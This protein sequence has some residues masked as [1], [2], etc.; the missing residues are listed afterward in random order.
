MGGDATRQARFVLALMLLAAVVRLVHLGLPPLW[1]DEAFSLWMARHSVS[2]I[3][4]WTARLDA[5]PP[6]Y[7]VL[8]H[9]W[10][11]LGDRVGTLRA[12]SAMAELL[13]IP[14]A[15]L[16]G[17]AI[18]GASLGL[19]TA[20]LLALSPFNVWYGQEARM[21]PL[22]MLAA[23][24]ALLGL[25][26]VLRERPPRG[27]WGVYVAG[28]AAAVWTEHSAALLLATANVI[29]ILLH[30]RPG[31]TST[32]I[33]RWTVAQ[34]LVVFA[35]SPILLMLAG[36]LRA[37]TAGPTSLSAWGAMASLLPDAFSPLFGA[38]PEP[39]T[40][41]RL[42]AAALALAVTVPLI[43]RGLLDSSTDRRWIPGVLVVWMLPLGCAVL[44]GLAGFPLLTPATLTAGYRTLIWTSLVP[45]L[46]I[47]RGLL[48]LRR[49]GTRYAAVA[50]VLLGCLAGLIVYYRTMPKWEAWD[51]AA[52]Y[53]A[54]GVASDD[55]IL[56]HDNLMQLPFDYYFHRLGL[57]I[58]EHGVPRDF[59]D[60]GL[61]EPRAT[62][63][64]TSRLRGVAGAYRRVW[65]V[66][67]HE[68]WTDPRHL[69]P[70]ALAATGRVVDQRTFPGLPAIRIYVF[71]EQSR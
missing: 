52:A 38:R 12:F 20:L 17:R 33:R 5:H 25:V 48:T 3:W 46:L 8:L 68:W 19:L 26:L 65:L 66:Y 51:R 14:A 28:M 45:C 67:S 27:A 1:T 64:D 18:G 10:L 7:Y 24:V 58:P 32:F 39:S 21:Y 71:Q 29:V 44:L 41:A 43:V 4:R 47:A 53:V 2:D 62:P 56:F 69:V 59:P 49:S 61:R 55:V 31:V 57:T 16:L 37:G 50:L 30:R 23:T 13:T 11:A 60:G 6:L 34:G 54:A 15:Y 35:W 42:G 9:F 40:G 70:Q 63:A 36:Q 22:L